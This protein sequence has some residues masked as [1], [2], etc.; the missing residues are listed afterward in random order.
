M[1]IAS[2]EYE[3]MAALMQHGYILEDKRG[4]GLCMSAQLASQSGVEH[5][6]SARY[7]GVSAPPMDTLNLGWNRP[8]PPENV[9]E[10]FRRFCA[11]CGFK[12]ESMAAINYEHGSTVLPLTALDRGR[13]FDREEL[14]FCDGL[15]TNDPDITLI[16]SHADCG[17]FFA[18]DPVNRAIGVAHA[19][20]KGTLG[21]IGARMLEAMHKEYGTLAKDVI[22]SN[23]PCICKDCF[24]VDM[25]LALKFQAE[26]GICCHGPGKPGKAQLDLEMASAIQ[27]LDAGVLPSNITL[28]HACTY[29]REDLF[30]SHRRDHG[31][32]G[33][34][35]AYIR[36]V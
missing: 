7:G 16:T 24:E 18:Y 19:G 8:E 9:I 11:A 30:F 17:A 34:M 10:N 13:G 15:I 5:G 21:R 22:A 28:M 6:F 35:S 31:E 33:S 12:Y 23:G 3:K 20:W 27:L 29:E 26:F 25:P 1:S 36:L 14:P 4:V 32:T 2:H